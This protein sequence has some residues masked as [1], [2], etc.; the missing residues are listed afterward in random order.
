MFHSSNFSSLKIVTV[1]CEFCG[2]ED[3]AIY[4]PDGKFPY[5]VVDLPSLEKADYFQVAGA[6]KRF[7]L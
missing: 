4:G 5:I 6:V 7:G 1:A 2:A 3:C